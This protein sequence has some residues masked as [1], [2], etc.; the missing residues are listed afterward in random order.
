MLH[1]CRMKR[2]LTCL[3]VVL[4]SFEVNA[5]EQIYNLSF[6]NWSKTKS[7]WNLYRSDAPE[8]ERVWDSANSAIS[9]LGIGG[10]TTPEYAHVAVEGKGKAACRIESKKI[11]WTLVSG[12]VYTGKYLRLVDF[13][14]IE[15]NFGL[16]FT[17]RP[18]SLSGYYHY[19]PKTVDHAKAPYLSM[20]GKQDI[21][22][23]EVLLLDITSPLV[24][25]TTKDMLPEEGDPRVIGYARLKIVNATDDY[26]HFK[27]DFK[28]KDERTPG[29]IVLAAASSFYGAF[30][31]GAVGSVLYID[32]FKL[33]Y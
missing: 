27:L 28:Y 10:T 23:I 32:E 5:Q 24:I 14:G 11:L 3:L 6:D 1:I 8:R 19:I 31:T 17:G 26:V 13:K 30:Y 16:P 22:R 12:N 9:L 15:S 4:C 2:I 21:G 20:K 7:V 25:D 18:K 33:N 29:Y